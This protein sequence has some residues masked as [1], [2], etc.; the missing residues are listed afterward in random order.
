[1]AECALLRLARSEILALHETE[2]GGRRAESKAV[3]LIVSPDAGE[4]GASRNPS[5]EVKDV[6]K[7]DIVFGRLIVVAVLVEPGN[8]KRACAAIEWA[9]G[10]GRAAIVGGQQRRSQARNCGAAGERGAELQKPAPG[11]LS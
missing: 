4:A 3:T 9:G 2:V 6:G 11:Y 5:L 1:M 10:H 8:G 7:L